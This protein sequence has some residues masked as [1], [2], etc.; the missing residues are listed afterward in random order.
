MDKKTYTNDIVIH[1]NDW[2]NSLVQALWPSLSHLLIKAIRR[3]MEPKAKAALEVF[4][5]GGLTF[6]DISVSQDPPK[7]FN[8][9]VLERK[10]KR[11]IIIDAE[12]SYNGKLDINMSITNS[13]KA[14]LS[15]IKLL[16]HVRIV[17]KMFDINQICLPG[18]LT[19]F[20][21]KSPEISY[22]V[23][24]AGSFLKTPGVRNKVDLALKDY[25]DNAMT[26]PNMIT[27]R[28]NSKLSYQV[29]N[30]PKPVGILLVKLVEGR[31]LINTDLWT[32][33]D[34]YVVMLHGNII[35]ISLLLYLS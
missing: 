14:K 16:G 9:Q 21:S 19:I 18:S 20:F 30:M 6:D 11:K 35:Y 17:L 23:S 5:F 24:G 32:K 33:I 13:M 12:V 27:V 4:G 25:V 8:I 28:L 10:S 31:E 15:D 3:K 29:L 26:L 34:P 7:L 1:D 22:N 2:H